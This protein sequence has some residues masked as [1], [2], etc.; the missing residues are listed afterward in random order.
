MLQ[1]NEYLCEML[2][3]AVV[4]YIIVTK[5]SYYIFDQITNDLGK[6]DK[7][8]HPIRGKNKIKYFI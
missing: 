3:N 2:N 4:K 5:G 6:K 8:V 1:K 7:D